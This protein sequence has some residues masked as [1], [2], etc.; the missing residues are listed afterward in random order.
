MNDM[1]T[2]IEAIRKF[3]ESVVEVVGRLAVNLQELGDVIAKAVIA[4]GL[5]SVDVKKEK[6]LQRYRRR[7]ERMRKG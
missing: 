4:T 1:Q 7:G 6:Y 5:F 2:D 3:S